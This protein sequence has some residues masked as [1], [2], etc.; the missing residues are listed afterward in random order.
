MDSWNTLRQF[1]Q[2]R[3]AQRR[4]GCGL[5]TSALLDFQLAH[6]AARDAVLTEWDGSS[7]AETLRQAGLPTLLLETRA[8]SRT[9]YLLRPDHGRLLSPVSRERLAGLGKVAADVALILSNGLSSTAV[10]EHGVNLV[11]A[12][13]AVLSEQ[14]LSWGSIYLVP[15]GR[16]ALSDEV[17]ALVGAR[18]AVIIVGERPGLSAADSLGLYLT[19]APGPGKSDADRNC[20]SNIR[21]PQGLS[22]QAAARKFAYLALKSL[23]AG[24]SGVMLKD[25]MPDDL[26]PESPLSGRLKQ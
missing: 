13:T 9:D 25:D 26:L 20:L 4:A 16:V 19:H 3:I 7:C 17:G 10:F 12:I 21:P 14:R 6:A 24:Y 2:A 22:Y 23:A 11:L 15:N 1:T 8:E 5:T 18:L